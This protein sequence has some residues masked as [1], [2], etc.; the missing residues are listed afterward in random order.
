MF[1][2]PIKETAAEF[3]AELASLESMRAVVRRALADS[4]LPSSDVEQM[5]L[6]LEEAAT[7]TIRH[8][9]VESSGSIK[10]VITLYRRRVSI[11]LRDTGRPYFPDEKT[12]VSLD[13]LV[14][15][16]RKGG[17]GQMMIQR[18]MDDVQ[19]IAGDGY[20]ELLMTKLLP[21]RMIG[22]SPLKSRALNLRARF[23][24]ATMAIMLFVVGGSYYIMETR[25][26][27]GIITKQQE[28]MLALGTSAAALAGAYILNHRAF[29]EF[30]ELAFSYSKQHS[31]IKRVTIVDS[32][33]YI[34]ADSKDVKLIRTGYVPPAL[35]SGAQHSELAESSQPSQALPQ[36]IPF[37]QDGLALNYVSIPIVSH[38][39][40]LGSVGLQFGS[41][42]IIEEIAD[43]RTDT[44][45]LLGVELLVGL[46]L[47]F[48]LSN[49]FVKPIV[50]IT[51]QVRRFGE[52][53]DDLAAH[54]ASLENASDGAEEFFI[55]GKALNSMM[56]RLRKDSA[57]ALKRQKLDREID[58]AGEIQKTLLPR[59]KPSIPGLDV[60]S[61][62][63]SASQVG[64]DLYDVFPVGEDKRCLV[65]ADVSG[66]GVPA[67]LIMSVLRTVI[68]FKADGQSSPAAILKSVEEYMTVDIP[69]GVFITVALA[70]YDSSSSEFRYASAGHNPLIFFRSQRS[71]FELV[72]P[73]GSPLGLGELSADDGPRFSEERLLIQPGDF[74]C[75]YTDG[76]SDAVNPSGER[77]GADGLLSILESA[78][79]R[80]VELGS[81]GASSLVQDVII[82]LDKFR[83][84]AEAE[85]DMTLVIGRASLTATG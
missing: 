70:I 1:R 53:T 15:T 49:Y 43:A 4:R 31:D 28:H 32:A 50:A 9:Y 12:E 65:V 83:G 61:F 48:L 76:L 73:R 14:E 45:V 77:L 44:F 85:D 34:L 38:G 81:S 66:K 33:N 20:N 7:N 27:S 79:Q 35:D 22:S 11:S 84:G 62:Y 13:R 21:R 37:E 8:S 24:M 19:Y 41:Q 56:T 10:L 3:P 64:G 18:L 68:R 5:V 54:S 59:E 75:L 26:V 67:S 6:A 25:V 30:D 17:L 23:S 16:S 39:V 69:S 80:S 72:N 36:P 47:I 57:E 2:R 42:S 52:G 29:V 82:E 78:H 46:I 60:E 63:R 51:E 71:E 74:L 55:I 58:L 40:T